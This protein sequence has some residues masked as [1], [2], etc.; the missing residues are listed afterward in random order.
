MLQQSEDRLTY[1]DL[2][3]MGLAQLLHAEWVGLHTSW[4][5]VKRPNLQSDHALSDYVISCTS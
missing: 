3:L 1:D 5:A 2:R 4:N